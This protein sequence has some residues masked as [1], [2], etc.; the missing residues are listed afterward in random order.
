M[1]QASVDSS[2]FVE[3]VGSKRLEGEEDHN[4]QEG[5]CRI[6]VSRQVG[7]R[8]NKTGPHLEDHMRDL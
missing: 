5:M 4:C 8:E 6:E 2:F 1:I 7:R 3:A